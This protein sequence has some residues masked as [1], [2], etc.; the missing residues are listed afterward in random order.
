VEPLRILEHLNHVVV[1]A[2]DGRAAVNHVLASPQPFDFIFM[3]I[4]MPNLN[5]FDASSQ[6]RSHG[7]STPIIAVTGDVKVSDPNSYMLAGM[8][9]VL[10]K[11][12]SRQKVA[13]ILN[14]LDRLATVSTE[15]ECLWPGE[16]V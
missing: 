2:E 4:F 5:G 6:I 11:P 16:I 3:D 7:I 9:R 13:A 12:I 14:D 10:Q 8:N 1:M 15:E